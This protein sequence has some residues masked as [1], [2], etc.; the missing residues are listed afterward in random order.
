MLLLLMYLD[1]KKLSILETGMARNP[2][3]NGTVGELRGYDINP[4]PRR[5][6]KTF[7]N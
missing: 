5:V 3:K 1:N 4:T 2:W 6:F 7:V